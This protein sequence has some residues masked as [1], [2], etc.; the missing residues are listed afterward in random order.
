MADGNVVAF[1]KTYRNNIDGNDAVKI[2][3]SGENFAVKREGKLLTI[4]AKSPLSENDT[5]FY[6]LTNLSKTTYKLIFASENMAATGLQGILIDKYLKTET[7]VSLRDSTVI[8]VTINTNAASSAA[9]RFKMAFRQMTAL[10]VNIT[11]ITAINKE[12]KNIIHW[13]V[14]NES[15]IRQYE[16]EKSTDGNQFSQ[17]AVVNPNNTERGDYI[18]EDANVNAVTNYYRISIVSKD[19]KVSYSPVVK[20]NIG[21]IIAAMEV[22]PNPILNRTIHLV[23]RNEPP[24]KYTISL[25]NQLGQVILS[26]T[27]LHTPESA[28]ESISANSICK[29]IY[30][31]LIVKPD[32]NKE[33]VK[34][35]Y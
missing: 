24:G 35:I 26:K 25:S 6:N 7:P 18:S 12:E 22:A 16:V 14:E 33:A 8:E 29:G 11:S 27:I 5:I 20:V 10:P 1:D 3:N 17:M 23:F 30:D 4:E 13:S 28:S 32:G 15:G 34:I 31:L 9:D 21:K 2:V 19:G